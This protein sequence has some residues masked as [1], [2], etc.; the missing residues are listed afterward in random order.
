MTETFP[1]TTGQTFYAAFFQGANVFDA[2]AVAMAAASSATESHCAVTLTEIGS[3]GLFYLASPAG[4]PAG[5][6]TIVVFKQAGGSPAFRSD[7]RRWVDDGYLWDGSARIVALAA[8]RNAA[9]DAL[10]DRTDGVETGLT[11]RQWLRLAAAVLFGKSAAAG[12]TYRDFGDT[13]NRIVA[14]LDSNGNRTAITRDAT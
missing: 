9:A 4:L 14:T 10:L 2:T 1:L 8:D 12:G 7:A 13:K 6:Y 3:S 5:R 11:W